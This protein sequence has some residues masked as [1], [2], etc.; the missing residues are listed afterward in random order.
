MRFLFMSVCILVAIPPV[1][2]AEGEASVRPPI[3]SGPA[4]LA[5]VRPELPNI[6]QGNV[7][8]SGSFGAGY[9]SYSRATYYLNP[10]AEYF[11]ANRFSI[12]GSIESSISSNYS[13]YGIGP[14][15][16]YYFWRSDKWAAVI[17][18]GV[19]YNS[20][21]GSTN[22]YTYSSTYQMESWSAIGKLGLS[23]FINPSVSFGP[24][25]SYQSVINR[26]PTEVYGATTSN[27]LFQLSIFL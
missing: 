22:Y 12:G 6:K 26:N 20:T 7:Q 13:S 10:T 19:L 5:E 1:A 14:S 3:I 16:S 23:Y 27:L 2:F 8:V 18:T 11:V 4:P 15:L 25:F 24:I 17:G 9:S 21:N